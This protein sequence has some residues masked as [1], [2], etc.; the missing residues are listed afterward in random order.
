MI[1]INKDSISHINSSIPSIP[2]KYYGFSGAQLPNRDL[3]ICGGLDIYKSVYQYF[4]YKEGS[5]QWRKV[6]TMKKAIFDHS[7]VWIDGRF[8]TTG[9]DLQSSRK[10]TSYHEEFSFVGGVK[11]RKKMLLPLRLH[12]STTFDQ[13]RMIVCGGRDRS[14]SQTFS[15]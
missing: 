14:V 10:E 1:S 12:T 13:N 9:D 6:G 8:L 7:S 15:N 4:H 2:K 5:N 11:K 3:V